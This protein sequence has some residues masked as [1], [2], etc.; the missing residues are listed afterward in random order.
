MTRE[1]LAELSCAIEEGKKTLRA[2]YQSKIPEGLDLVFHYKDGRIPYVY[3]GVVCEA[4]V[5]GGRLGLQF[6]GS[7]DKP[8]TL[9][10][11]PF[12]FKGEFW[13]VG[14]D[15]PTHFVVDAKRQ[16][17]MDNA[18]GFPLAR[19]SESR[20]LAEISNDPHLLVN[21]HA[22]LGRKPPLPA[23]MASALSAGWTP[24]LEFDRSKYE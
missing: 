5:E 2:Q 19:V 7:L 10:A 14:W 18:H 11:L 6:V 1:E 13:S 21:V 12:L 8:E 15:I 23:W 17:W 4:A 24:P 16:C 9:P 3:E 22:A 20:L